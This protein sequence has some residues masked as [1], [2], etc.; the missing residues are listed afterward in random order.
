MTFLANTSYSYL[1]PNL[2][3]SLSN[4]S[5]SRACFSCIRRI[6][7]CLS[8][9][10]LAVSSDIWKMHYNMNTF[11]DML[12]EHLWQN[13]SFTAK[14]KTHMNFIHTFWCNKVLLKSTLSSNS[15]FSLFLC[16]SACCRLRFWYSVSNSNSL[17]S[18]SLVCCCSTTYGKTLCIKLR[19]SLHS[20]FFRFFHF[21]NIK[22]NP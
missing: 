4:S 10:N 19:Q 12:R 21:I 1:N 18:F 15:F 14:R 5:N 13:I 17:S 9:L 7:S 2:D 22:L 16:A 11:V 8:C 3:D 6:R 20:K